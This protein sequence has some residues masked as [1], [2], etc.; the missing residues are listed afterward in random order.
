MEY[1]GLLKVINMYEKNLKEQCKELA[2][3]ETVISQLSNHISALTRERFK[4]KL[5]EREAEVA[6]RG[7]AKILKYGDPYECL[8]K[9]RQFDFYG[10]SI[11]ISDSENHEFVK[12]SLI[13]ESHLNCVNFESQVWNSKNEIA[14][15]QTMYEQAS[16]ENG[17][18][19]NELFDTKKKWKAEVR[20]LKADFKV[21]ED[22]YVTTIENRDR[23]LK[24]LAEHFRL[25]KGFTE[26]QA[27]LEKSILKK[28]SGNFDVV[29]ENC[30]KLKAI[31]RVPILSKKFHDLIRE[32]NMEEY[33]SLEYV[34]SKHYGELSDQF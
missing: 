23:S 34:Y 16:E 26:L 32:K 31:L 17:R 6:N 13:Q 7:D 27:R 21:K 30:R 15:L 12:N 25:F 1:D 20:Q 10:K 11:R 8:Y 24:S 18:L 9:K 19:K 22:K 28:T 29:T 3:Q 14:A 5:A 4:N 33:E 2:L